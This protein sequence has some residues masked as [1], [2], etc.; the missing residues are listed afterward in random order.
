VDSGHSRRNGI[1][2]ML[3]FVLRRV[4]ATMLGWLVGPFRK[5]D[6]FRLSEKEIEER[7]R[8]RD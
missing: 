3:S 7:E 2:S 5:L 6:I 4:S 1:S 8:E